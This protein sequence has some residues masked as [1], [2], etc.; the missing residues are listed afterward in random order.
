[1]ASGSGG[2]GGDWHVALPAAALWAERA[3]ELATGSAERAGA[4]RRPAIALRMAARRAASAL[5]AAGSGRPVGHR[6]A[7]DRHPKTPSRAF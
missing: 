5:L 6:L 2:G 7:R 4:L 1:M 3:G